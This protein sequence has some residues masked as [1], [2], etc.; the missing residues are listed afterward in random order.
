MTWHKESYRHYL[1][2]KGIKTNRYSANKYY[3]VFLSREKKPT[4]HAYVYAN[5]PNDIFIADLQTEDVGVVSNVIGHEELHNLL[6]KDVSEEASHDL[7]N[8]HSAG[9]IDDFDITVGVK[10]NIQKHID[11]SINEV[12]KLW[13]L[14]GKYDSKLSKIDMNELNE[15]E[16]K[17]MSNLDKDVGKNI[18]VGKEGLKKLQN[19]LDRRKDELIVMTDLKDINND[20]EVVHGKLSK[21]NIDMNKRISDLNLF[22]KRIS[23]RKIKDKIELSK[24]R[25]EMTVR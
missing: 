8:I 13:E 18:S 16:L 24:R 19:I 17:A 21:A 5:N 3:E 23:A 14:R 11:S 10:K 25:A 2:A 9:R 12:D 1:A 15:S 4:A 22:E 6:T 7:D 20:S